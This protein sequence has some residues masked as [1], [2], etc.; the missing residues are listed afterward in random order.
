MGNSSVGGKQ[1][2]PVAF[3]ERMAPISS[4]VIAAPI[5]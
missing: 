1:R 3:W 5:A 4:Y 2:G